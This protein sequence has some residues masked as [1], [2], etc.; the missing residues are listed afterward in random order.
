[1]MM[2][3]VRVAG[4]KPRNLIEI[5]YPSTIPEVDK[6]R[7]RVINLFSGDSRND[8]QRPKTK[9]KRQLAKEAVEERRRQYLLATP[10]K[11]KCRKCDKVKVQGAFH[12]NKTSSTGFDTTCKMCR[13]DERKQHRINK[14]MGAN[15]E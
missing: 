9:S 5:L 8:P 1:M 11:E 13:N 2:Q 10:G 12:K 15:N 6:S 7:A 3:G 14:L 4:A